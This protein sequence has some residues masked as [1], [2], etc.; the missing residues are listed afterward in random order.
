[1][2]PVAPVAVAGARAP[3]NRNLAAIGA[4][5]HQSQFT[6]PVLPENAALVTG[7]IEIALTGHSISPW[8]QIDAGKDVV[9]RWCIDKLNGLFT[10]A[11]A[12]FRN[13][14]CFDQCIATTPGAVTAILAAKPGVTPIFASAINKFLATATKYQDSRIASARVQLANEGISPADIDAFVADPALVRQYIAQQRELLRDQLEEIDRKMTLRSAMEIVTVKES[15]L[16]EKHRHWFEGGAGL[17]D[18]YLPND[19]AV[20]Y[21]LQLYE[22]IENLHVAGANTEASLRDALTVFCAIFENAINAES[23]TKAWHTLSN[24]PSHIVDGVDI[25]SIMRDYVSFAARTTLQAAAKGEKKLL[26]GHIRSVRRLMRMASVFVT[27]NGIYSIMNLRGNALYENII[28]LARREAVTKAAVEA[29][30]KIGAGAAGLS[31]AESISWLVILGRHNLGEHAVGRNDLSFPVLVGT[32]VAVNTGG[33][34]NLAA[35]D[36]ALTVD[37]A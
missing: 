19:N 1:M 17:D 9:G 15:E 27:G 10:Q 35:R 32:L 24:C 20:A 34:A 14:Y 22:I 36:W 12:L 18:E 16:F 11:T 8:P 6:F 3:T 23:N 21:T 30:T 37:L 13:H 2:I 29:A 31:D 5:R 33:F 26:A 28:E 4:I 7:L 25:G